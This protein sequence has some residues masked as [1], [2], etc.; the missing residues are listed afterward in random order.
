MK[1]LK[2]LGGP[3]TLKSE[4]KTFFASALLMVVIP[5]LSLTYVGAGI[6]TFIFT[7]ISFNLD[8]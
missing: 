5:T 8:W 1:I 3:I 6:V 2:Y 7:T 4:L